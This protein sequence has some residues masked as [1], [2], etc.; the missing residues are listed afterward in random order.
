MTRIVSDIVGHKRPTSVAI[1]YD[2]GCPVCA[3]EMNHHQRHAAGRDDLLWRDLS[4]M[5]EALL[6]FGV[7]AEA[8][9]RRLHVVDREGRL[10]IGIDAFVTLWRELP[11]YRWLAHIVG[12]PG[13]R[14]VSG[15]VYEYVCVPALAAW[16]R[17]RERCALPNNRMGLPQ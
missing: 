12:L 2:G 17:R 7:E 16:N 14:Q 5:P 11:G 3:G 1:F 9:K 10:R 6:C 4:R 15:V 13:V 8:A